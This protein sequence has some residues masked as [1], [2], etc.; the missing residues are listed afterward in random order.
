MRRPRV[1]VVGPGV[2]S[3][4]GVRSVIA[5][6]CDSPL[7][8]RFELVEIPTHADG[9]KALK[10]VVAARGLGRLVDE[11][12]RRRPALV[13]LHS[14]S[15]A[16][17][18]R[19]A[20]AAGL[21]RLARRPYIVHVHG[22]AFADFYR[23]SR[24]PAQWVIRRM[25]RGAR[26]V[27]TLTPS[28]ARELQ[29][30]TGRPTVTIPNPVRVPA[31]RADPARR[32]AHVVTLARIGPE[33]GSFV[34]V[35][36]FAAIAGDHPGA[37]LVL[38]GDGSQ[39]EARRVAEETGVADRLDLT[40]WIGPDAR[41]ALLAEAAV[42]VLPSRIEGLPVSMLEAM[43]H[44]LPVVVTPVGG[45]PDA[46]DDGVTGVLVP[47]DDVERLAAAIGGLLADPARATAMGAAAREVV[48]GT[49]ELDAVAVRIGDLIAEN[50]AR[51]S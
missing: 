32:P 36:A 19:K 7:A 43:A 21:T 23:R 2:H 13:Y 11:L 47:I 45:I 14:A 12:V 48:A 18:W 37:R 49:Y 15:D 20:I 50:L 46:I 42:F 30:I 22:G 24:P 17:F 25:L 16:S 28:W 41:D 34:L 39:E 33:K 10:L 40:G 31:G 44:A 5:A 38:A 1:L 4:G 35:R 26:A 6:L 8:E 3:A 51:D 29:A 9:S 27:I